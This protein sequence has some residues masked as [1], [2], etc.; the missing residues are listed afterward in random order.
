MELRHTPEQATEPTI[1]LGL[2]LWSFNKPILLVRH[3]TTNIGSSRVEDLKLHCLFDFD[4]GGPTSY[5]DDIGV[6]DPESGV[7]MAYD[8][9]RLSVAMT[10]RPQP[11]RWEIS[12]PLKL[13]VTPNRR[14][15]KNNLE[16]GPKDIATG[17]QWNLGN[18]EPGESK[19][20][21]IVLVSAVSQDETSSLLEN[22]WS[23]FARKI[24]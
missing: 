22:A 7:I 18:I 1:A 23:L 16:L 24:R 14:D 9:T 2:D 17:L 6:Y 10:S 19:S 11:D 4:V 15:L 13:K 20:V 8:D 3:T 12:T 21:D 5:K